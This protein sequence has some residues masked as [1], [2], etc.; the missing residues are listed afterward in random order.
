M[1]VIILAGGF[2][3]RLSE[4]TS[5]LPKPLIEI[6]GR[7]LI[8][9]VMKTYASYGFNDFVVACGYKG[10]KLHE[11]FMN[12]YSTSSDM[13]MDL[14]SN[15]VEVLKTKAPDWKVTLVDTGLNTMTGGRIKKL[16]DHIDE[17]TFM[18]T[19]GDGISDININ[20][21]LKFHRAHGKKATIT[22]VR[23]PRFGIVNIEDSGKVDSFQEKRLDNSPYINAGYMVLSKSVLDYIDGDNTPLESTPLERLCG[24]GELFAYKHNGFW[25]AVDTLRDKIELEKFLNDDNNKVNLWKT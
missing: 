2:G 7:P 17:D 5:N 11:Y 21:L 15:K 3:A 4:L 18:L 22:A 1:K 25:K 8:W 9:Y 12:L 19:Y 20:E 10:E 23:M 14:S 13:R 6:A 24:E 16:A